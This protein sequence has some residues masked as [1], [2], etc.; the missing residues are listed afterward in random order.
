[1]LT[2]RVS[3]GRS[4]N[5][6]PFSGEEISCGREKYPR[7]KVKIGKK[8][9]GSILPTLKIFPKVV[10]IPIQKMSAAPMKESCVMSVSL[11]KEPA[12]AAST[13]ILP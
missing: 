13:V 12:A 2:M 6:L 11:T 8:R 10:L 3:G 4:R 1:M 7:R 9:A 5:N